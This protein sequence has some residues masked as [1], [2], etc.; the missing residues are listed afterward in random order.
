MAVALGRA[1]LLAD[2]CQGRNVA[3]D[4]PLGSCKQVGDRL[5]NLRRTLTGYEQACYR[6]LGQIVSHA[7]EAACRTLT[8]G[9]TEREVAGQLSHRLL[10]RGASPLMIQV[11][12]DGRSRAY[13]HGG[14]TT[15]SVRTECV[16][17]VTARKYGLCATAS[18][19]VCFGPPDATSRREHET[20]CKVS[21]A[22]IASSWPD[23]VVSLVMEKGRRIYELSGAEH[24]W[25][26]QPQG[27]ITGRTPVE[28]LLTPSTE[29]LMQATWAVTWQSSCGAALSCDTFL[30]T[31]E[32]P[33][34]VTAAENWP[35]K[36]IRISGAEFV[37]PDLLIR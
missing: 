20:V 5:R 16:V 26:L 18:R 21:A 15:T 8:P 12:A 33:R 22:Y 34:T 11:A 31:E 17:T 10:H 29:D 4:T 25:L 37:R 9:E 1:Q 2:L 32:G 27:Y 6:A 30:L 24:E 35:L 23:S 7:L 13:R 14:F 3:C 36:R 19:S 28:L